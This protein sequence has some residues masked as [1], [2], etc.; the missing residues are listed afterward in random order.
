MLR[1]NV[2][3]GQKRDGFVQFMSKLSGYDLRYEIAYYPGYAVG[4]YRHLWAVRCPMENISWSVGLDLGRNGDDKTKG[5][6]EFNPNK[7]EPESIFHEWWLN[8]LAFIVTIEP[9]RYDL[10]I[11]IPCPRSRCRLIKDGKKMYQ[12]VSKDDGLTEYLGRRSTNGFVKLYDKTKEAKL[13]YD[14]TRLEITLEWLHEDLAR[15]FPKVAITEEQISLLMDDQLTQNER[16]LVNAI[17]ATDEPQFYLGQLSYRMRKKIEP[18]LAD[19]TLSLDDKCFSQ[20]ANLVRS[21]LV[22]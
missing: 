3:F 15:S 13:D 1:L 20:V 8:F 21:Y 17:K 9:V 4:R 18:Y 14:L 16:V 2:D 6:V 22:V 7:C 11:D 19:T 5:F 12:L 10:A